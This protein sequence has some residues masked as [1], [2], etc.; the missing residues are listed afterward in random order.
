MPST[1]SRSLR[2]E[3]IAAGEQAGT[4]N[5]TTNRNLGDIIEQGITGVGVINVTSGDRTLLALNAAVDEARN[6]VLVL[7][8]M[9]ER[10][11]TLTAPN[12]NKEY[13]IRNTTNRV[14]VIRP[15]GSASNYECP[16]KSTNNIVING[17]DGSVHGVTISDAVSGML[18][19]P[20][21]K[22]A[23][24]TMG[25]APLESPKFT[26]N[27]QAD[28]RPVGD[29]TKSLATT[30]FVIEN[31][32]PKGTIVM[33][34]GATIPGGWVE[35]NG[36]NGTPD[37]RGM[38]PLGRS[39]SYPLNSTGGSANAVLVSH[40]HGGTTG[41]QNRNHTHSGNTGGTNTTHG[42]GNQNLV[43]DGAPSGGERREANVTL[44]ST[45]VPHTHAFTTGANSVNHEHP[46]STQGED[47]TGKNMPPY[48]ALVF[49][50]KV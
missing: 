17:A 18:K 37:L 12:V 21:F 23:L 1:Y 47:G 40:N 15:E 45:T 24:E 16:P 26:G 48:R 28:T 36:T 14:V 10:K 5:I 42:G 6:A 31:G 41:S 35:C 38:F 8:G 29:K 4:W 32:V 30:E 19:Q 13:T 27:P 46:I 43:Y 20:S 3:L 25:A 50:M 2:I 44:A 7:T 9:P 34:H 33:W 39:P 49:I 11:L 22:L